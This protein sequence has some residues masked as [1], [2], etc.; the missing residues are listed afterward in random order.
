MFLPVQ[1]RAR[2][3]LWCCLLS[4]TRWFVLSWNTTSEHCRKISRPFCVILD[5][6][7]LCNA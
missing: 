7:M 2:M 6:F 5:P 4:L 3:S 1:S